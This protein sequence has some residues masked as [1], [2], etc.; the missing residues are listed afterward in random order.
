MTFGNASSNHTLQSGD[1]FFYDTS[2]AVQA[3]NI[4]ET[5]EQAQRKLNILL[6]QAGAGMQA[7][8]A[9]QIVNEEA[10]SSGMRLGGSGH[11]SVLV[12]GA[13]GL[14]LTLL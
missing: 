8:M 13:L 11:L 1:T 12:A 7:A 3:A 9:C 2:S 10:A 6:M 14:A 4:S 5:Y